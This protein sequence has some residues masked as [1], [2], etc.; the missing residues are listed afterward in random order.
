[1][2]FLSF[3]IKSFLILI[4]VPRRLSRKLCEFNVHAHPLIC[5]FGHKQGRKHGNPDAD[6]WAGA[7]MLKSLAIQQGQKHG[8]PD[9]DGWAEALMPELLGVQKCHRGTEDRRDG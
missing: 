7:L 3:I 8:N 6:G 2:C 1:M 5:D 9:A 4:T